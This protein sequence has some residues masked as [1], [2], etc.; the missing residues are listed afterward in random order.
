[1]EQEDIDAYLAHYGVM[2]M[3][4]GVRKHEPT[5][6]GE[7][8][9]TDI[10]SKKSKG[11]SRNQKIVIAGAAF[12]G[13]A[14]LAYGAYKAVDAGV[15]MQLLQR[16]EAFIL[17]AKDGIP[18]KKNEK[19]ADQTLTPDQ[20]MDT[21]V[22]RINPN[23]SR[24]EGRNNC[25]RATFAYELSR[26][27]YDVKATQTMHGGGSTTKGLFDALTKP[28]KQKKIV[29]FDNNFYKLLKSKP[30]SNID[31]GDDPV[32]AIITKLNK[33]PKNARGEL[34][35]KMKRGGSHS[36]AVEMVGKSL[37]IFDAQTNTQYRSFSKLN[38]LMDRIGGISDA[39][40]TRLDDVDLDTKFL[41]RWAESV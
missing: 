2:G 15:H 10:K 1:M 29:E 39:G 36:M 18:W 4:W 7:S 9:S 21:V 33:L 23:Y 30:G 37:T 12:V 5:S 6:S 14:L 13:T 26:R 27:G 41:L 24:T 38:A 35:F 32:K 31:L 25:R 8:N 19:L 28:D 22:K 34:T 11:L 16:G 20:I 40:F 17:G 3:R